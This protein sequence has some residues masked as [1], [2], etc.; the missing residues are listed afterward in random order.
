MNKRYELLI[1]LLTTGKLGGLSFYAAQLGWGINNVRSFEVVLADGRVVLASRE[2][3]PSLF[4]ALRG[5]GSNFGIITT[6][7]LETYPYNGM[8]GG[9]TLVESQHARQAIE[10]YGGFVRQLKPELDPKGHT[11]VIF[12][13]D[14][15]PLQVLQYLVY[16]EPVADLPMFDGLR[17]VPTV[18]SSLG[19]TD[20]LDLAGNIA[21]L[22]NG[23]GDR[24]N[25]A[26][27]TFRL[28]IEMLNF[29][30]DV[31][32]QEAAP[33]AHYITGT[34]E[35]HAIPRTFSPADNV[36]GLDNAEEPLISFLLIFGTKLERHNAELIATQKRI[37]GRV[38]V[39][40]E[41][42]KLYHPF[43]FNNYSGEWQD[44]IGSFGEDNLKL[45]SQAAEVYDPEQVFQHLQ[46]G[47]Y[48]VTGHG[49]EKKL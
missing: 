44:V 49:R 18:E 20:Y 33:I 37:I 40:A 16:T 23:N 47:S 36:Y 46:S 22:Q 38:Q 45:L 2:S 43:L 26:T 48:K 17:Q 29:A 41:R 30:F 27:L 5:G 7:E 11:I 1:L 34:M 31:F 35:F 12:T 13:Y 6:F 42:R 8:W 32:V 39:E 19:M 15:G 25:V 14:E 4:R 21:D 3:E 9:R 28:D 10:A 24:A